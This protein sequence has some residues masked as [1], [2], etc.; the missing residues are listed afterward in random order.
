MTIASD[1][2]A[3]FALAES[4]E[5]LAAQ[6]QGK[7]RPAFLI[8]DGPMSDRGFLFASDHAL[9]A[10]HQFGSL[11]VSII[12]DHGTVVLSERR[13]AADT[14]GAYREQY[15]VQSH[16]VSLDRTLGPLH[17]TFGL[18]HVDEDRTI[19][20]AYL[21]DAL[22][23]AGAQTVFL[24]LDASL[25]LAP[26]WRAG[27]AARLGHTDPR[28]AGLVNRGSRFKSAA[29]SLDLLRS[30]VF[31]SADSLGLRLSQPL[32]GDAGRVANVIASA[33][34]SRSPRARY[35]V[36]QDAQA[37]MLVERLAPTA[38]KD[39]ISRLIAKL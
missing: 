34:R 11:G 19:L 2:Q 14:I 24:D 1:T 16:A 18:A 20:G 7:V 29:W 21:H 27:A 30:G 39:R 28:R 36:G 15:S 23:S 3:G 10:R 4:A 9:A 6:L 35:L 8:A 26:G 12:A 25:A 37:L 33:L 17:A 13:E 32:M 31:Q 5:G 38:L 22:G